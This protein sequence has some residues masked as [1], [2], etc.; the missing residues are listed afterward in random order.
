[1]K[2]NE[3]FAQCFTEFLIAWL[4]TETSLLAKSVMR[5]HKAHVIEQAL[6]RIRPKV[7]TVDR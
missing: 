5:Y 7:L 4:S 2:N 3:L 6:I 1:M